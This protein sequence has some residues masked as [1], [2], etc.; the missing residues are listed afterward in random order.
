MRGLDGRPN[1]EAGAFCV[2]LPLYVV[3]FAV[4]CANKGGA[5]HLAEMK[6]DQSGATAEKATVVEAQLPPAEN[7][8]D[9]L[10]CNGFSCCSGR[11]TNTANDPFNCGACGVAC[12]DQRPYCAG[13][14]MDRP[15][16]AT[17]K[18]D[19]TCCGDSCC[20]AGEI[21]CMRT[22]G[23]ASPT[24][25]APVDGTCPRGCNGCE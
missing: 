7:C 15:C 22:V 11:C 25:V 4:S 9:D 12:S 13:R 20:D 19:E 6:A 1:L 14:C 21:C 16:N 8:V 17:C 3:L 24:C 10:D 18:N 2:Q 23:H 5:H